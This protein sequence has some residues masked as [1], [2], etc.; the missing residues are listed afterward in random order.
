MF[1]Q[2]QH[3]FLQRRV[4][5]DPRRRRQVHHQGVDV[6]ME[7]LSVNVAGTGWV[8]G[9]GVFEM[10]GECGGLGHRVIGYV[11]L[12]AYRKSMAVNMESLWMISQSEKCWQ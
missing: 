8:S 6:G 10:D 5:G 11:V 1:W 2:G 4:V 12:H 7:F 9:D 3:P